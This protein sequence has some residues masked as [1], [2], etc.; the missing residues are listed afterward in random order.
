MSI[1]AHCTGVIEFE[2]YLNE[3]EP[4]IGD[5]LTFDEIM[6]DKEEPEYMIPSGS[7]GS[8][9]LFKNIVILNKD[10]NQNVIFTLTGSLRDV[11]TPDE[12]TKWLENIVKKEKD[13]LTSVLFEVNIS[14]FLSDECKTYRYF[15]DNE[16][17]L[18]HD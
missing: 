2:H 8:L 1:W 6:K 5:T 9:K 11:E 10:F 17:Q 14:G 15:L 4:F 18:I 12:I 13:R 16:G 3:K 7:E